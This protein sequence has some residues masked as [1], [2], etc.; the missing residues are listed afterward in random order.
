MPSY[1]ID[2][3]FKCKKKKIQL[4]LSQMVSRKMHQIIMCHFE[5]FIIT[6]PHW[7][8]MNR[9]K[10][11][12]IRK[13]R[14]NRRDTPLARCW[15]WGKNTDKWIPKEV[16]K[17]S[18]KQLRTEKPWRNDN[19]QR[20]WPLRLQP[21]SSCH[22]PGP[23]PFPSPR[24]WEPPP[25]ATSFPHSKKKGDKGNLCSGYSPNYNSRILRKISEHD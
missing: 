1:Y 11:K 13:V 18:R 5:P 22:T 24:P 9:T 14:N 23:S 25:R 4:P 17:V 15:Q 16:R 10:V 3:S 7:K 20:P 6:L 8:S 2:A 21:H 12:D 19:S